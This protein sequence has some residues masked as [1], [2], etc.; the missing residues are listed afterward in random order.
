MEE[1]RDC[2]VEELSRIKEKDNRVHVLVS[3]STST[4][5]IQPFM[6]KYP[7]SVI[8]TGI[9]E[10]NMIGI[11]AGMSLGGLIPFTANAA[12]FLMGR[13]N[14]QVKTDVCYS[15]TN[16]KLVGLN[17]GFAYGALGPTH[18]CIDDISTTISF[19]NIQ[20]FAPSDP[21]ETRQITRYAA[22]YKGPVYIRLDSF[23]AENVHKS[24]YVFKPGEAVLIRE[25]SDISLITLGT[26][27]HDALHAAE[28]LSAKGISAEVISLPSIRP[29]DPAGIINSLKKTG[30]AL[31][32]EEHSTH[33]GIGAVTAEIILDN[34]I[35]CIL[36][37][38]GVPAGTFAEA[39]PRSVLK[40][41]YGL[42][43]DSIIEATSQIV[44][45]KDRGDRK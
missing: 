40:K 29:L 19:G 31:T 17:P 7:D 27:V 10:Q 1:I 14:E 41:R 38:A 22:S 4:C 3:D 44:T 11:A 24:N 42:D 15:E 43:P 23:K 16:V 36:K 39:A 28:R 5:R 8:N 30:A 13:S 45:E 12:P 34:R 6:E 18:H 2:F 33:G 37:R 21:E 32:L 35:N 9:A 26:M 20:I 25:G